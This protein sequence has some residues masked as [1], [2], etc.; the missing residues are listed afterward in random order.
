MYPTK[1]V[2]F[3]P[4]QESPPNGKRF[5]NKNMVDHEVHFTCDPGFQ[6]VGS[7]SRV[8]QPNGSWTGEFPQCKGNLSFCFFLLD[9][10]Y[11]VSKQACAWNCLKNTSKVVM[12]M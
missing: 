11:Q 3:C 7:S 5:G 2:V 12:L 1:F 9:A 8:C 4:A 10:F 6:L